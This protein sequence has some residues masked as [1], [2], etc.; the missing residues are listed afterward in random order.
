MRA[1]VRARFAASRFHAAGRL[2]T[3]SAWP[4]SRVHADSPGGRAATRSWARFDLCGVLIRAGTCD[5]EPP[6]CA[7]RH[8]AIAFAGG[9]RIGQNYAR[10]TGRG[11]TLVL[12]RGVFLCTRSEAGYLGKYI[13]ASPGGLCT[14]LC[15]RRA[16]FLARMPEEDV[17]P[18]ASCG[19]R[20]DPPTVETR[21]PRAVKRDA[22]A[23]R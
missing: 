7:N 12:C 10:I 23:A 3:P 18:A 1:Y 6:R 15:S 5:G 2:A 17:D 14:C 21:P 11:G 19:R 4:D 9:A 16:V 13:Q 22:A 8:S 20:H